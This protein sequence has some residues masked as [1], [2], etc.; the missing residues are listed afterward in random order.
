MPK[1]RGREPLDVA[2][3]GVDLGGADAFAARLARLNERQIAELVDEPGNA[4]GGGE[5]GVIT[6]AL[7]DGIPLETGDLHLGPQ[8][9]HGL[10]MI[11]WLEIEPGSDPLRQTLH[12]GSAEALVH[13]ACSGEDDMN[14]G[15]RR[16]DVRQESHFLEE[17]GGERV[18]LVNEDHE[19]RSAG[20]EP[21]DTFDDTDPQF[22]LVDAAIRFADLGEHRLPEGAAG[23][24]PGTGEER[25]VEVV[26]DMLGQLGQ[27]QRLAGAGGADHQPDPFGPTDGPLDPVEGGIDSPRRV[28]EV[29]ARGGEE[30]AAR[31]GATRGDHR[32]G[33]FLVGCTG[34][35]VVLRHPA[36][37]LFRPAGAA[38]STIAFRRRLFRSSSLVRA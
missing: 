16:G 34:Q 8:V 37:T 11:E 28:V 21:A 38:S 6:P 5:H 1:R 32:A 14:G 26:A 35:A 15:K 30:R 31:G 12:P 27:Q 13:R 36:P 20:G 18:R 33:R 2:P 29:G 3:G 22:P 17:P 9:V 4:V 7:E 19:P 23:A 25:D 10:V 24:D